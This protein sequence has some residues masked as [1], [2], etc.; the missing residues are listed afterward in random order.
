M[1]YTADC[2]ICKGFQLGAA[3]VYQTKVLRSV[4]LETYRSIKATNLLVS[5]T[6]SNE[7]YS[8]NAGSNVCSYEV[9][10]DGPD[11]LGCNLVTTNRTIRSGYSIATRGNGE[12]DRSWSQQQALDGQDFL[13]QRN[14]I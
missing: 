11:P 6:N 12:D 9:M 5:P 13:V 4:G 2:G 8:P 7:S 1:Y 14:S 10:E 3:C